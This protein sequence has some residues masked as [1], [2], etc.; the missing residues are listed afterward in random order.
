MPPLGESRRRL[1]ESGESLA[2]AA[3]MPSAARAP[4][5]CS[6]GAAGLVC[7]AKDGLNNKQRNQI[8][9]LSELSGVDAPV[10]LESHAAA[11]QWIGRRWADFMQQ[12]RKG[13]K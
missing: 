6:A 9:M 13:E 11:N 10:G 1:L 2:A 3:P 7:T 12:D 4:Q 5:H 8:Q